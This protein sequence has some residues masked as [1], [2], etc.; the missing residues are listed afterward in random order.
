MNLLGY[1]VRILIACVCGGAIGFERTKRL[2]EAGVRTHCIIAAASALMMIVSKYGFSDIATV[3]SNVLS[4]LRGADPARIAAQV[5][6]GISFLGAGVI[7]RNG[8]SVK[9]LTTAAGIWATSGIGLAIG[10]GLHLLGVIC[11]V[12]VVAVQLWFHRFSVGNDAFSDFDIRIAATASK[13]FKA[14]LFSAEERKELQI[15]SIK[16]DKNTDGPDECVITLRTKK[17]M[18]HK[19]LIEYFENVPDIKSI[20]M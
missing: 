13:E 3:E 10:C 17:Q 15:L 5:I 20:S 11:S 19:Q 18:T 1:L 4:G 6:S 12:I 14:Y 9:G 16:V 8:N 2:K 7:F